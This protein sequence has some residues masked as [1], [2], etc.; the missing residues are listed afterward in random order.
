MAL[1]DEQKAAADVTK[2]AEELEKR[3]AAVKQQEDD[4]RAA[5]LAL[6]EETEAARRERENEAQAAMDEVNSLSTVY[7]EHFDKDGKSTV[8]RA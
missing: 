1:T 5:R 3:E 2:Q 4:L 6:A 7:V 8:K